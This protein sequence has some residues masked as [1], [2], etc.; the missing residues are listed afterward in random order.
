MLEEQP[1]EIPTSCSLG[2]LS[3]SRWINFNSDFSTRL[4]QVQLAHKIIYS[5]QKHLFQ[6]ATKREE[7]TDNKIF[8]PII[9][10][11]IDCNSH[12]WAKQKSGARN[13]LLASDERGRGSSTWTIL[14]CFHRCIRR[15]KWKHKSVLR[16]DEDIA[17]GSLT[18]CAITSVLIKFFLNPIFLFFEAL[19]TTKTLHE[20]YWA[21]RANKFKGYKFLS[22]RYIMI[23]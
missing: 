7:E 20:N 11:S 12:S 21:F 16:K 23:F 2:L 15:T 6:R 13:S 14:C 1:S 19:V 3:L 18:H 4:K 17:G 9:H 22:L 10:S 5:F 8:H